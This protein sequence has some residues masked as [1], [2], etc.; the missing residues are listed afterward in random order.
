MT[1]QE[2]QDILT[3]LEDDGKS[4]MESMS[5]GTLSVIES[6][7]LSQLLFMNTLM[8]EQTKELSK[9]SVLLENPIR[10]VIAGDG[11]PLPE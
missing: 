11:L 8:L 6:S 2:Y 10:Q 1:E 4:L 7:I 3:R 9:I 5:D